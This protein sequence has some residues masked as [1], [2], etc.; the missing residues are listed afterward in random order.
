MDSFDT[1]E[2][3][4]ILMDAAHI[5]IYGAKEEHVKWYKSSFFSFIFKIA[6]IVIAI[7][8]FN[9]ALVGYAMALQVVATGLAIITALSPELGAQLGILGTIIGVATL[10][11]GG[12]S[13]VLNQ[14]TSS[15]MNFAETL[16][17]AINAI[18]EYVVKGLQGDMEEL[19][20]DYNDFMEEYEIRLDEVN[21][22]QKILDDMEDDNYYNPLWSVGEDEGENSIFD[23]NESPESFY[24]R[25]IHTGNPGVRTLDEPSS[26]VNNMLRLPEFNYDDM[27]P[28]YRNPDVEFL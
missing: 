1:L 22:A 18:S 6:A 9:P 21:E 20:S 13:G 12:F 28:A 17:K 7:F 5:T 19:T 8:T 2:Q 4:D 27:I 10:T 26:F 24:N 25:T 16:M 23:A 3:S 11:I 14:L 15:V